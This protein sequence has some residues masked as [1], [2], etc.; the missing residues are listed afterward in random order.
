MCILARSPSAGM[1]DYVKTNISFLQQ[2]S[3]ILSG[4]L[5][6]CQVVNQQSFLVTHFS[7]KWT[8]AWSILYRRSFLALLFFEQDRLGNGHTACMTRTRTLTG[9]EKWT[10]FK[11]RHLTLNL[12]RGEKLEIQ[13]KNILQKMKSPACLF[14]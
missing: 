10:F 6:P 12:R 13:S 14:K 7:Q 4:L 9:K 8:W 2:K 5:P 1:N 11:V 3:T